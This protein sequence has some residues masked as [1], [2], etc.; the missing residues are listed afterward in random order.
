MELNRE[1]VIKALECCVENT[2]CEECPA[3]DFCN[4]QEWL[5]E[6]ALALIRELTEENERIVADKEF[7]CAFAQPNSV[8]QCPIYDATR[9]ARDE[10]VS[11]FAE[12]LK[13]CT[14]CVGESTVD[15]PLAEAYSV[16]REDTIDQI[17]QEML[18]EE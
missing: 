15:N 14:E 17:A 3:Y 5:V 4:G 2:C 6:N 16:V 10:A 8:S 9:M 13:A 1:Q 12:R 11:E 18:E 7:T